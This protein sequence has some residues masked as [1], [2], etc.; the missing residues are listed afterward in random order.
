M[1]KISLILSV[2]A[3]FVLLSMA[4]SSCNK[5]EEPEEPEVSFDFTN[6]YHKAPVEVEFTNTSVEN[7]F[8]IASY[9]WEFGDESTSTEENPV[10]EYT[11]ADSYVVTLKGYYDGE[12]YR[13][14]NGYLTVY[15][16]LT[17][18]SLDK[19]YFY[20]N[21]W[22][23]EEYP[24]SAY[25][26][27]RDDQGEVY[28]YTTTGQFLTWEIDADVNERS[29]QIYDYERPLN[30]GGFTV[31]LQEYDGSGTVDPDNDRVI[32]SVTIDASDFH[33]SDADGPYLPT[34]SGEPGDDGY[35]MSVD[36]LE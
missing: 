18:W 19:F 5:D 12:N 3:A 26:T 21:A 35:S 36:W 4:F 10:H 14:G 2:L 29:I 8:T 30:Q 32:F 28:D 25:V 33:P 31:E 24:L 6:N 11:E 16:E 9:E 27:V 7:D 23:G 20:P 13:A 1:K 34:Y 15:G 17:R 22:A